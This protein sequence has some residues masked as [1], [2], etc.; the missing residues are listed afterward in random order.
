MAKNAIFTKFSS[1]DAPAP[2]PIQIRVKFGSGPIVYCTIPNVTLIGIYRRPRPKNRQKPLKKRDLP[3]FQVWEI[4]N[5]PDQGQIW[6]ERL[7]P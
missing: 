6:H 5:L 7:V 4:R 1:L 2:T 3:R